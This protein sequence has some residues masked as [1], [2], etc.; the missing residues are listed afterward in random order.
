MN[1]HY[2]TYPEYVSLGHTAIAEAA[3]PQAELKARRRIDFMTASRVQAME[4]V[5]EAV[6][7]CMAALM[8]M[9]SA[10]GAEAQVS[11]PVATSFSTDGYSE[12]YGNALSAD[13]AAVQMNKLIRT[14]L[15]GE[16]DDT[17]VPLLYRG[18][19]G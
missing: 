7:I 16:T 13:S 3:Y 4:A 8:D 2:L 18:A 9:D 12:S 17:G 15:Y 5:P 19:R 6:K 10:V 11:A 14:Y 1:S